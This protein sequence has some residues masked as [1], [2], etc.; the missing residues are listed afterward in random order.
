MHW[1]VRIGTCVAA[2]ICDTLTVSDIV[3]RMSLAGAL[4]CLPMVV[5]A[6]NKVI[7]TYFDSGEHGDAY[8]EHG[9]GSCHIWSQ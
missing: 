6:V 2:E 9:Q 5:I 4:R 3:I 8:G 1:I 7:S